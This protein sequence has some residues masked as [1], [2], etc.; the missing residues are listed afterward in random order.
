MVS[1]AVRFRNL[2]GAR[3]DLSEQ[4]DLGVGNQSV[5]HRYEF[6]KF[7]GN[8]DSQTHEALPVSDSSPV[9]ADIGDYEGAQIAAVNVTSATAT[10]TATATPTPTRTPTPT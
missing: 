8:Y 1:L 6:Y 5:T 4:G 10:A 2:A 3:N 9:P 7:A